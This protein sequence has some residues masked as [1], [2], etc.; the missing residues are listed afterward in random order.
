MEDGETGRRGAK[1][2]CSSC[3]ELTAVKERVGVAW[4]TALLWVGIVGLIGKWG[5][6]LAIGLGPVLMLQYYSCSKCG[7]DIYSGGYVGALRSRSRLDTY[8]LLY[9]FYVLPMSLLITGLLY[10]LHPSPSWSYFASLCPLN[11]PISEECE[12]TF[13]NQ[14]VWWRG[15]VV[16]W[17][18]DSC[19]A[20]MMDYTEKHQVDLYVCGAEGAVGALVEFKGRL[21]EVG[22]R[23]VEA[24]E[25]Q[26]LSSSPFLRDFDWE[27][28]EDPP[29]PT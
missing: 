16:E 22:R 2:F 21:R 25:V 24:W 4:W 10:E 13:R 11:T 19:A 29:D 12:Q 23:R 28:P 27:T 20:V 7:K 14:T 8:S 5:V 26:V 18:N 1:H 6:L 15:W 3:G 9:P 17:S